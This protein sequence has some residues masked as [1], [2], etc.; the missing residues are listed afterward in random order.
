MQPESL[1]FRNSEDIYTA[2]VYIDMKKITAIAFYLPQF[3]PIPENDL[4]WGKG[5]TEWTNVGKAK[6]L[7][8]GHDQPKVPADLG[9][10]DLRLPE[11][12]IAQA[13][14]AR[15]YG[16]DGFCYY[17]YWF[18]R[19]KRLL[20]RPFKEVLD[21]GSPDFPFMLCWANESWHSKFWSYNGVYSKKMLIEQEYG[22]DDEYEQHF[23]ALLDAFKDPR[24][25]KIQGKPAFMIYKPL[26]FA[27]I[28]NFIKKWQSLA[29][30]NGLKG[31]F[32]IAQYGNPFGSKDKMTDKGLDAYNSLRLFSLLNS[33]R[34]GLMNSIREKYRSLVH[35]PYTVEY[36]KALKSFVLEEDRAEDV[37]PSIIPNWDH[38][39][40]SG[41]AGFVLNNSTPEL[42]KQHLQDVFSILSEK[43]G[44]RICF[45]KSW[46]E[47]GEGNYMEPDLK[48]GLRY[49]E[50]FKEV[51]DIYENSPVCKE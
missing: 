14:L 16:I 9:Y 43:Q 32:F 38:T 10:Y 48:Y 47:W 50:A 39:P 33:R 40:R 51:K 44:N 4:W 22:D 45:I 11:V 24:Y 35:L 12:R 13:E 3:H 46:N 25:I 5:F 15:K 1:R 18:G 17:H 34:R 26:E 8:K 36:K 20:E 27:N 6:P 7:F 2:D 41:S 49:L 42:F 21:S 37:F 30:E 28:H 19:G 23:Y 31:I 29:T